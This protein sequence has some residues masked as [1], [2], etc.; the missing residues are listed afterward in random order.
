MVARSHPLHQMSPQSSVY[1]QH[2]R[3]MFPQNLAKSMLFKLLEIWWMRDLYFSY[4]ATGEIEHIFRFWGGLAG[5]HF[6]NSAH[7]SQF[8]T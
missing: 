4:W 5:F 2:M 1:L 3:G 6:A 8:F 7:L